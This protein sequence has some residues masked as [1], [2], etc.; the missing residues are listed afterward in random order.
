MDQG[1]ES[2]AGREHRLE[3]AH[4][5]ALHLIDTLADAIGAMQRDHSTGQRGHVVV[6]FAMQR[7]D[8]GQVGGVLEPDPEPVDPSIVATNHFRQ[9]ELRQVAIQRQPGHLVD[10]HAEQLARRPVGRHQVPLHV[11]GHHRVGE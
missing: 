11:D 9:V 10:A 4:L 5:L 2:G 3:A 1:G 6:V 7:R 8:I